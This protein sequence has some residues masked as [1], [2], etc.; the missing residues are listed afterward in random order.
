MIY[1]VG[2]ADGGVGRDQH[3]GSTLGCIA[4]FDDRVAGRRSP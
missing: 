2:H 4:N 3:C 1:S